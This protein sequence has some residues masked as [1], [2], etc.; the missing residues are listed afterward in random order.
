MQ[1]A[2]FGRGHGVLYK[3]QG[4]FQIRL[5]RIVNEY[6]KETLRCPVN[7]PVADYFAM[8]WLLLKECMGTFCVLDLWQDMVDGMSGG[9][10][11]L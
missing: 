3:S 6:L 4:R 10:L 9:K 7:V 11:H 8:W 2:S 5:V 1:L